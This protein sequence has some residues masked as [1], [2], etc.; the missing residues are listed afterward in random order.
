MAQFAKGR[1]FLTT[2]SYR[3]LV[4][5]VKTKIGDNKY[6]YG[7]GMNDVEYQLLYSMYSFPNIILP[8]FGGYF[9]DKIGKR[10]GI[11]V[12]ACIVAV[13]QFIFAV[14][15]HAAQSSEGFGKFL[16]VLGRF[17]FGIGGENLAVTESS[18]I[19]SWFKGKE[20]SLA[21]GIDLCVTKIAAAIND[22]TQ[23]FFYTNSGNHLS[24]GYWFGFILCL[25]SIGAGYIIVIIDTRAETTAPKLTS[26][27]EPG[28]KEEEEDIGSDEVK[29]GDFKRFKKPYWLLAMNCLFIYMSFM[30]FMNVGSDFMINRFNI[31]LKEAGAILAL[32]YTLSAIITPFAGYLIDLIGMKSQFLVASSSLFM[33]G[34]FYLMILPQVNPD[35]HPLYRGTF[36]FI[37]FGF[38]YSLYA[39]SLWPS[40]T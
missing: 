14:S 36:A 3:I 33:L 18:Y 6:E 13:G 40:V 24:M 22:D 34:H 16:M 9:I 5:P 32:P 37:M 23:P 38:G 20:L 12:F 28:S 26:L 27:P 19:A 2:K 39:T 21:L 31:E 10:T 17:I 4:K 25:I 30:S 35:Q 7:M 15:T 1:G 29:L 8:L 11:I